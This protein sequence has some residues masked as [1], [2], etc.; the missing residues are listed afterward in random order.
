[1]MKK[2]TAPL[3]LCLLSAALWFSPGCST[4]R[5]ETGGVYTQSVTNADGTVTVSADAA[6]YATDATFKMAVSALDTAFKF[7]RD[8]RAALWS[9][10]HD[11]KHTMDTV[12]P[13]AA[14]AVKRYAAARAVYIQTPI[15]SRNLTS[16]SGIASEITTLLATASAAIASS[17]VKAVAQ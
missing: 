1:M 14:D 3:M 17:A 10:S 5:L 16:V 12:R 9:I 7:E 8:N 13:Q 15:A 4:T 6:L 2:L 11:I